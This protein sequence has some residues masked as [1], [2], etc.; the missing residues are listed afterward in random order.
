MMI[1]QD[2]NYESIEFWN[3]ERTIG[4]YINRRG[5]VI[6]LGKLHTFNSHRF[7]YLSLISL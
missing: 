3:I 1:Y 2:V 7:N 5:E 4:W 6:T